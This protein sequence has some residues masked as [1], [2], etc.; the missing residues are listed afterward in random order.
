MIGFITAIFG[1]ALTSAYW[2]GITGAATT[3]RWLVASLLVVALFFIPRVRLTVTHWLGLIL[4]GWLLLSLLWSEGQIDGVDAGIKLVIVATAFAVGSTLSDTRPLLIGASVGIGVSS[5]F[6]I[7]QWLGWSGIETY[8]NRLAGLFYNR[9]R[10]ASAAAMVAIWLCADRPSRLWLLLPLVA[11]SLILAPSRAA[12]LAFLVGIFT[13]RAREFSMST[14]VRALTWLALA[15][16]VG[17]GT[18]IAITNGSVIGI[19]Q[20]LDLYRDTFAALN[21]FGHGLGSFWE[22]FPAHAQLF[23]LATERPEHPHS[24]WLWLTYEGGFPAFI[25]GGIFAYSVWQ[26]AEGTAIRPVLAGIFVFSLFAMPFHDPVTFI[27]GAL[28]AGHCA[29]NSYAFCDAAIDRRGDVCERM[30]A[31]V[32]KRRAF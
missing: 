26:D 32:G 16:V 5:C 22:S 29:R 19:N 6:V 17:V 13:I 3:P 30:A 4:I 11:P 20:R 9:D 8:D 12:W 1:F 31:G 21:A 18:G 2:P 15:A 24:E 25:L 27:L 28:L 14:K 23:S 7:A 10:L